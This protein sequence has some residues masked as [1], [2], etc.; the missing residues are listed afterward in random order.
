MQVQISIVLENQA[1][2]EQWTNNQALLYEG[3]R[4]GAAVEQGEDVADTPEPPAPSVTPGP[5]KK[6]RKRRT[7]AQ[8]EADAAAPGPVPADAIGP[9]VEPDPVA[10][11]DDGGKEYTLEDA[12]PILRAF[13]AEHN[14]PPLVKKLK[15]LGVE[16]VNEISP[17][18]IS[19]FLAELVAET[20]A[21]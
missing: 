20:T 15:A 3:L 17:Q 4:A 13:I 2:F 18:Y 9:A 8:M 1:E 10:K 11:D 21:V 6:R 14:S 12:M 19:V 7:K 16:R 5:P